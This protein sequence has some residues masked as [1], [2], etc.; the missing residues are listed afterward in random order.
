MLAQEEGIVK[1]NIVCYGQGVINIRCPCGKFSI[2]NSNFGVIANSLTRSRQ[3][4]CRC[5]ESSECATLLPTV[6]D[7]EAIERVAHKCPLLG[8]GCGVR[9]VCCGQGYSLVCSRVYNKALSIAKLHVIPVGVIYRSRELE[10]CAPSHRNIF[11]LIMVCLGNVSS[12]C[13]GSA[14]IGHSSK[15]GITITDFHDLLFRLYRHAVDFI[16]VR[17]G[18]SFG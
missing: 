14:E 11:C 7:F 4:C 17:K 8:G 3:H 13:C 16:V 18:S 2:V 15:C 1:S 9:G 10:R 6:I 12:R 5:C